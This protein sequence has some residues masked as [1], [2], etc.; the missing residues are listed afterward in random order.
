MQ[1]SKQVC[2]MKTSNQWHAQV[3]V[4]WQT[5]EKP[6]PQVIAAVHLDKKKYDLKRAR[7]VPVSYKKHRHVGPSNYP[8]PV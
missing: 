1:Q 3:Q 5:K 2:H 7:P 6:A 8:Y 4:S